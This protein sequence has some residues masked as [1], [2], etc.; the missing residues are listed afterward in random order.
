M[1]E[2]FLVLSMAADGLTAPFLLLY[3]V[4]ARNF[5]LADLCCL[6]VSRLLTTIFCVLFLSHCEASRP[7]ECRVAF[8]PVL[9]LC[10]MVAG[11]YFFNASG[12][13]VLRPLPCHVPCGVALSYSRM[14]GST[15]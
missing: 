7:R 4:E 3:F 5:S 8:A 11:W 9:V 2:L 6:F 10:L 14:S 12:L 15:V 13:C 1:C